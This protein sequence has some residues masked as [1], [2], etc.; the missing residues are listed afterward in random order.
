MTLT[1][2]QRI[3]VIKHAVQASTG[4]GLK[5]SLEDFISEIKSQEVLGEHGLLDAQKSDIEDESSLLDHKPT[6]EDIDEE[7]DFMGLGISDQMKGVY[8]G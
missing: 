4:V 7:D 1:Q 8:N 3:S 2:E 6:A 5:T